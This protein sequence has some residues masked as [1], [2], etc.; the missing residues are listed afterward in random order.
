MD[1]RPYHY[2]YHYSTAALE[3]CCQPCHPGRVVSLETTALLAPESMVTPHMP[4]RRTS[5]PQPLP[6]RS[7]LL[8]TTRHYSTLLDTTRHYS[9]LPAA[10]LSS[11]KRQKQP[12]AQ[13]LPATSTKNIPH[14]FSHYNSS[15]LLQKTSKGISKD[16]APNKPTPA[17][18]ATPCGHFSR[19]NIK[20]STA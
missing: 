11:H 17:T 5:A 13:T 12:I 9:T 1:T 14:V 19:D 15:L 10:G 20:I 8:D 18:P 4:L 3:Q 16:A 2:H 6:K 7:T